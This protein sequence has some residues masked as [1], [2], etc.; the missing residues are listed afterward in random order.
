DAY[1]KAKISL[2]NPKTPKAEV[3]LTDGE[4]KV[5]MKRAPAGECGNEFYDEFKIKLHHRPV[6]APPLNPSVL[7]AEAYHKRACKVRRGL[8]KK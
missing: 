6:K 8:P 2:K 3:R 7:L 1:I 5:V 4:N